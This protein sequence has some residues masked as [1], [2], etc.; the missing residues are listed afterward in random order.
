MRDTIRQVEGVCAAQSY[1]P[2]SAHFH[3]LLCRQE[4]RADSGK[5]RPIGNAKTRP[6][7]NAKLG[8]SG[9]ENGLNL[10]KLNHESGP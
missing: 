5:T 4:R 8:L 1:A 2:Q 3:V 7:G 9:T 6:I 10:M